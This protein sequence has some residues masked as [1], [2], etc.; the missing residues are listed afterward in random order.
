MMKKQFI[1]LGDASKELRHAVRINGPVAL[2]A[3]P[4]LAIV[5]PTATS[6][7]FLETMFNPN[8]VKAVLDAVR[9]EVAVEYTYDP[10]ST[11]EEQVKSTL[12][13]TLV[14]FQLVKP[15]RWF[16]KYWFRTDDSGQIELSSHDV[17]M[18]HISHPGPYLE[19]QQHHTVTLD[20]VESVK[21][22]LP[23]LLHALHPA[24]SGSWGHPSGSVHRALIMFAQGYLTE[25]FGEL[26]QFLWAM[27]LDS[28][29]SSKID[30][31]KRGS[32]TI[33]PRLRTLH[34]AEFEP[35]RFVSVPIHQRRPDH[36]LWAVAEDIFKLRNAVAHGL[37]IPEAWLTPPGQPIYEGYAYQLAEC[38]EILLRKTL[39]SIMQEQRLFDVFVDSRKLDKYFG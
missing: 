37:T 13:N 1:L 19:Y 24:P 14:A 8:Q 20:D 30:K 39:L 25:K 27:A 34:G 29:F 28:L 15:T 11:Q 5:V 35:Y 2:S 18:I 10:A 31:R 22:C 16:E 12:I 23:R 9:L 38:T 3:S 4:P 32:Y 21:E 36:K 26:G 7:S 17:G 33:V 6:S